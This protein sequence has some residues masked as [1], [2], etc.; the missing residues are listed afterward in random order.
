MT[1]L[2]SRL[3]RAIPGTHLFYRPGV[4]HSQHTVCLR[5]KSHARLTKAGRRSTQ[6]ISIHSWTRATGANAAGFQHLWPVM[7]SRRY[8]S[9]ETIFARETWSADVRFKVRISL[10]YR[11]LSK[12]VL[13]LTPVRYSNTLMACSLQCACLVTRICI[14]TSDH[15][16]LGNLPRFTQTFLAALEGIATNECWPFCKQGVA[17]ILGS[18]PV[19]Q[20]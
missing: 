12:H 9:L 5:R 17:F 19:L 13:K 10:R 2:L 20:T 7:F 6:A 4:F 14:G 18:M 1:A 15:Q 11:V 3:S 16:F 8:D